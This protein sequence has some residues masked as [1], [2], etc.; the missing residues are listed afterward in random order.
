[1]APL[2]QPRVVW[3]GTLADRKAI[4]QAH[5]TDYVFPNQI[6]ERSPA[7]Q[8]FLKQ[9]LEEEQLS[10]EPTDLL[11]KP[12]SVV[13][14]MLIQ[15]VMQHHALLPLSAEEQC[16][17]DFWRFLAADEVEG[18]LYYYRILK[19]QP[20]STKISLDVAGGKFTKR[21]LGFLDVG[22]ASQCF[23]TTVLG[24]PEA[25]LTW[26]Q[27]ANGRRPPTTL[28]RTPTAF[29]CLIEKQVWRHVVL[30][31][32]KSKGITLM[33]G[34]GHLC[35]SRR[36]DSNEDMASD[37]W[38]MRDQIAQV[39]PK[40]VAAMLEDAWTPC[41][42]LASPAGSML[43]QDALQDAGQLLL[44]V[45]TP[46]S[47]RSG[48][49]VLQKLYLAGRVVQASLDEARFFHAQNSNLT[50]NSK[51]GIHSLL[52][53]FWLATC[54]RSDSQLRD[55]LGYAARVCL[56]PDAAAEAL[57]FLDAAAEGCMRVPSPATISKARG[58]V[59]VAWMLLFRKEVSRKLAAG[60][61]VY[62]QCDATWQAHREYQICLFNFVETGDLPRLHEDCG[63]VL[64][65][66]MAW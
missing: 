59:D 15:P 39:V 26:W 51:Y 44:G 18:K 36:L 7:V 11:S 35:V 43:V 34:W 20:L 41:P 21:S 38:L 62:V 30:P 5:R 32:I 40:S 61:H 49:E 63:S 56:P 48:A 1:M 66:I 29:A 23:T 28:L 14:L 46:G 57:R 16:Q 37:L 52:N 45:S 19:L 6:A 9:Y 24:V 42:V 50:R 12:N 4:S 10:L 53:H 2:G 60:L 64:C 3:L 55:V 31:D 54:L 25:E 33:P 17:Y 65:G 13:A 47:S 58:R 22:W 8:E 27:Q